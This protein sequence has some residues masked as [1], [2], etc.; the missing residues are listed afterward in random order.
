M[1]AFPARGAGVAAR[2]GARLGLLWRFTAVP[3]SGPS[4]NRSSGFLAMRV[5]RSN[6]H[7]RFL[8]AGRTVINAGFEIDATAG[9]S[10]N[11]TV[12]EYH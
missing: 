7:A 12:D 3:A 8:R 6:A 2:A 5:Q 11:R 4:L 1:A 10:R 9:V